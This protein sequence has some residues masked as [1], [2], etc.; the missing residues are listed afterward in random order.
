MLCKLVREWHGQR[1]IRHRVICLQGAG[2]HGPHLMALGVP[3]LALNMNRSLSGLAGVMKLLADLRRDPPHILQT[4]LYH[5]DL[6]GLIAGKMI[7]IPRIYWNLRCSDMAL[8]RYA[9]ATRVVF[10]AAKRLS[11]GPTGIMVNS[12]AGMIHHQ[13][14]GYRPRCWYYI[15][16]GFDVNR[17]HPNPGARSATRRALAIP[18]DA[19]VVGMVAR[20]DP[21]KDHALFFRAVRLFLQKKQS[22]TWFV[23]IGR[24]VSWKEKEIRDM[25]GELNATGRVRLLGVQDDLERFYPAFDLLTLTSAFGEGFPNVVGEAMACGVPCVATDVGDAARVISDTGIIVPP[26]DTA[27]LAAAWE[28]LLVLTEE[29]RRELAARAR[30][31]ICR[32]YAIRAV[33]RRYER[34]YRN[35]CAALSAS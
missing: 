15:P 13:R 12:V 29:Q 25:A 5:A 3:V 10:A 19:A 21:M 24:G 8:K 31:R 7:R 30:E 26:G 9:I 17:F 20:R 22:R 35:A 4:W 18:E 2:Y 16:N 32:R 23:V 14:Q 1:A 34:I 33:A 11:G 28:R 6:M 27:A